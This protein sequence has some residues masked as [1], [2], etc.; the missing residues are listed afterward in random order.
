VGRVERDLD[1]AFP[2]A[3]IDEDE[4]AQI[5]GAVHPPAESDG[6]ASV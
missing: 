4:A 1:D 5:S 6:G 3:K 2:I